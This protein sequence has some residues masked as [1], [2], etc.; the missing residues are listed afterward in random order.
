MKAKVKTSSGIKEL[1]VNL[2]KT[3][4]DPDV[5]EMW[6]RDEHMHVHGSDLSP[7]EFEVI[8]MAELVAEAKKLEE[9]N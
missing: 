8:N 9:V 3:G 2:K 5:I 4:S 7:D 1:D 6:V